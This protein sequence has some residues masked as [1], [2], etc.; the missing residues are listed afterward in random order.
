M[1][2]APPLMDSFGRSLLSACYML[3]MILAYVIAIALAVT[4]CCV[5]QEPDFVVIFSRTPHTERNI[6]VVYEE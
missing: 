1:T 3:S 5:R 4:A 6:S 2:A